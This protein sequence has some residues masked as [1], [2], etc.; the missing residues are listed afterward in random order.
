[1]HQRP[2]AAQLDMSTFYG[3]PFGITQHLG[4]IMS[5]KKQVTQLDFMNKPVYLSAA[6][7]II[8]LTYNHKPSYMLFLFI[9][10]CFTE[11]WGA[12]APTM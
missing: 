3:A 6:R 1:M 12:P 8:G 9:H 5:F 10:L 11:D 4:E 2:P 7:F